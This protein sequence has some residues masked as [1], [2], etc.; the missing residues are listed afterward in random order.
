MRQDHGGIGDREGLSLSG[1]ACVGE[2]NHPG[3]CERCR[4]GL[5]EP[6]ED[7]RAVGKKAGTQLTCQSDSSLAAYT[8]PLLRYHREAW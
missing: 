1:V 4:A 6:F 7:L 5:K 8:F 3:M 2:I